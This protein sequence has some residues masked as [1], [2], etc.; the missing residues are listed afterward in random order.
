M[1][2]L[3][4]RHTLDICSK[5]KVGDKVYYCYSREHPFTSKEHGWHNVIEITKDTN[6][7]NCYYIHLDNTEYATTFSYDYVNR[8]L[9][10][11]KPDHIAY[12]AKNIPHEE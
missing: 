5:L 8:L 1:N 10:D 3:S 6:Y 4:L 2:D 9:L 7:P 12:Y 11:Y